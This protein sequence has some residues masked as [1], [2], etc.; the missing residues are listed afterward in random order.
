MTMTTTEI[1]T[2]AQDEPAPA[3][4]TNV[5]V[6]WVD[7][8]RLCVLAGGAFLIVAIFIKQLLD[9]AGEDLGTQYMQRDSD[10][11]T[12][13]I[14]DV[15]LYGLACVGIAVICILFTFYSWNH[16]RQRHR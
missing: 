7:R 9:W 8:F 14:T 6:W 13:F 1:R 4:G 2:N 15:F 11:T 3:R 10:A 16:F 12:Y 5:V